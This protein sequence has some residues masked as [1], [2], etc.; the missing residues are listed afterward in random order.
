[1]SEENKFEQW[2][3]V[4]LFGHQRIAGYVTNAEIGGCSFVRVDVPREGSAEF[5]FTKY[6]GNGSIYA[7]NIVSEAIAREAA[8][9]IKARPV[10]G[11]DL[12]ALAQQS[13]LGDEDDTAPWP[14]DPDDDEI[15]I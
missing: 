4:E 2:A 10:Y 1:M 3:V 9:R 14:G 15:P 13:M 12:P 8:K 6:L 7:V 11:Y 5:E